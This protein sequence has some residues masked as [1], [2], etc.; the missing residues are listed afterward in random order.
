VGG[1]SNVGGVGTPLNDGV[2]GMDVMVA[3]DVIVT[4]VV[5]VAVTGIVIGTDALVL[6]A[7]VPLNCAE[8]GSD[9][10]V[11]PLKARPSTPIGTLELINSN[12]VT[13]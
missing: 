10:K 6:T 8:T 13:P 9:V 7:L 1:G 5:I 3:G 4:G 11:P 12:P 2:P